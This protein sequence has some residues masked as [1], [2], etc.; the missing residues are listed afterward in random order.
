MECTTAPIRYHQSSAENGRFGV[1]REVASVSEF[2]DKPGVGD[3]ERSRTG[4]ITHRFGSPGQ[5]DIVS[6]PGWPTL[7]EM[8]WERDG[9]LA[10]VWKNQFS[11]GA[12]VIVGFLEP[13]YESFLRGTPAP[14]SSAPSTE[15]CMATAQDDSKRVHVPPGVMKD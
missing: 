4:S 12:I 5:K 1:A 6:R 14:E 7:Q 9:V 13:P 3:T 8:R 10:A 15:A 2:A 11:D